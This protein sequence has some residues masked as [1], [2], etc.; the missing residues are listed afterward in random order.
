MRTF[1]WLTRGCMKLTLLVAV[2]ALPGGSLLL[3]F[4]RV[5]RAAFG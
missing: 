4:P 3:L 5:R 1:E 2:A